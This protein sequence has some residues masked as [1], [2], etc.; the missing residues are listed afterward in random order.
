M[1][2][3]RRLRGINN[4]KNDNKYNNTNTRIKATYTTQ[5]QIEFER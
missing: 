5:D 2:C 1:F 3:S 4:D